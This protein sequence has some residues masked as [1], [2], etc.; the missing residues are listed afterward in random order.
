MPLLTKLT[1]LTLI[2]QVQI[3]S[4]FANWHSE[5]S[6]VPENNQPFIFNSLKTYILWKEI[7]ILNYIFQVKFSP[8]R[9]FN[10]LKNT[11]LLKQDLFQHGRKDCGLLTPPLSVLLA[12]INWIREAV[13]QAIACLAVFRFLMP[14]PPPFALLYRVWPFQGCNTSST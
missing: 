3:S 14:P 7:L 2:F 10:L 5:R 1:L 4:C 13:G 9:S 8:R 6:S 11:F 12:Y